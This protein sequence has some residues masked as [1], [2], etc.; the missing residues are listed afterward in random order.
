MGNRTMLTDGRRRS[1]S[2]TSRSSRSAYGVRR[3]RTSSAP[4]TASVNP[5]MVLTSLSTRP[6]SVRKKSTRATPAQPS[7]SKTASAASSSALRRRRRA[8]P[9]PGSR[10]CRRTSWRGRRAPS[11]T[12]SSGGE[13]MRSPSAGP[14]R[15]RRSRGRR[16]GPRPAPGRRARAP[17]R[18]PDP[19][20]RARD[21]PD[22][23]ARAGGDRL[24]HHRVRPRVR[25]RGRR[26]EQPPRCGGDA[27]RLATS[28]VAHLSMA[29]APAAT[30]DPT[31]G[32]P[33]SS[34]SAA[35]VPSSPRGPCRAGQRDVAAAQ[36]VGGA[37]EPERA[38]LAVAPHAVAVDGQRDDVVPRR[39]ER[40]ADRRGG[41]ERDVVLAAAAAPDH[42]DPDPARRASSAAPARRCR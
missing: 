39:V 4:A 17:P 11:T 31:Y 28:L 22:A 34:H 35:R 29:S 7:A 20:R 27:D 5:G 6:V 38:V 42:R 16:R 13:T 21:Q 40:A 18:V 15:R 12:I 19:G 3:R 30:P 1:A 36:H 33:A 8:Q 32:R 41:G 23:V 25:R 2:L 26:G 9:G 37:G 14:A 10:R 24:D